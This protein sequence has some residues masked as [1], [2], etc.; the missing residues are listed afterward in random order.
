[1]SSEN[2]HGQYGKPL[3]ARSSKRLKVAVLMGG[4]SGERAVSHKSGHAIAAALNQAGFSAR[5]VDITWENRL[6]ILADLATQSVDMVFIALHGRGG[7]D[8]QIQTL[9][10]WHG[11]PYT[12]S[13]ATA[14]AVGMDKVLSKRVWQGMG[15]ATPAFYSIE[16]LDQAREAAAQ[17]GYPLVIKPVADGSSLGV[18]LVA[19]AAELPAAF[20][21]AARFGAVMAEQMIEGAELTVAI[22]DG[23]P[24]P[25]IRICPSQAHPF[26]DYQ[27]KYQADDTRYQLPCGLSAAEEEALARKAQQAF[28]GIKATGWGRVDFIRD[29][30]GEDW[31]IEVNTVPGMTNHSLFPKAALA[32]GIGFSELCARIVEIALKERFG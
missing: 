32:A 17:L 6:Q 14:S 13:K 12:G 25:A 15:L 29:Q 20:E 8:G 10:D 16:N 1:M 7:E 2:I 21:D 18:H 5:T 28:A 30:Q 3:Q 26:Y 11:I 31:L 9:L 27:A 24:L 22:L 19:S 23:Q 4:W